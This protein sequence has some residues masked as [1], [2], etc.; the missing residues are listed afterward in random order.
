MCDAANM[1]AAI[2]VINKKGSVLY[3]KEEDAYSH[4]FDSQSISKNS[5]SS[6]FMMKMSEFDKFS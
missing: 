2:G 6:P 5:K 3:Y 4:L 1:L